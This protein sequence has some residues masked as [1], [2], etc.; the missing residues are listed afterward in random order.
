MS[1][2]TNYICLIVLAPDFITENGNP[3]VGKNKIN[4]KDH[5]GLRFRSYTT[6]R[7]I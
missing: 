3:M 6:T 7:R 4:K 1:N 5:N 2:E